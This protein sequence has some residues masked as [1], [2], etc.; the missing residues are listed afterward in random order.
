MSQPCRGSSMNAA[1]TPHG[2]G[3]V[4]AGVAQVRFSAAVVAGPHGRS[5]RV[6]GSEQAVADADAGLAVVQGAEPGREALIG[7]AVGGGD[8]VD[9]PD[10]LNHLGRAGEQRTGGLLLEIEVEA[11]QAIAVL[12]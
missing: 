2:F 10:G 4:D 5:G 9:V 6:S 8:G 12:G 3:A 1:S 11:A 7:V